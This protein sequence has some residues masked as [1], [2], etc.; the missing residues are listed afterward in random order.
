MDTSKVTRVEV[1]NHANQKGRVYTIQNEGIAV[2][3]QLQDQG[4]TL[5]VFIDTRQPT[6]FKA[7]AQCVTPEYCQ[8]ERCYMRSALP[9]EVSEPK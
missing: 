2:E 5:K 7:C 8:R 6:T 3:V 9:A 4:R 1:I